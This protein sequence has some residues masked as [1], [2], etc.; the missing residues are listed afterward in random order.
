MK[1]KNGDIFGAVQPFQELLK[2][3]LPVKTSWMLA[4][5]ASK[6]DSHFRHIEKV[7]SELVLRL[8]TVNEETGQTEIKPNSPAWDQF[9]AGYNEL[10]EQEDEIDMDKVKLPEEVNGKPIMVTSG[11]LMALEKFIEV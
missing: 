9:V 2:I 5:L 8:G 4:K 6:V 7:R 11:V 10:M 1:V 3:E